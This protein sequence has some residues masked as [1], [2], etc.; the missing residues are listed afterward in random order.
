MVKLYHTFGDAFALYYLFDY[1]DNMEE[2]WSL[3][4]GGKSKQYQ[5]GLAES[6]ARYLFAQIINGIEYLHQE[7][8]VHRD[9]KPENMM[10]KPNGHLILIDFGTC[11]NMV[12]TKLNGPE[13]VGTAEYMSPEA[14]D[15]KYTDPNSG[16]V[17]FRVH[18]VPN[19]DRTCAFLRVAAN[20]IRFFEYKVGCLLISI[21]I[22][23]RKKGLI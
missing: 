20:I 15:N 6:Y 3:M 21:Q 19:A 22:L 13:F 18:I 4:L 8:I 9:L 1:T 7:G 10:V 17:E 23:C 14:I 11:K 12:N 16:P 5:I 2:L